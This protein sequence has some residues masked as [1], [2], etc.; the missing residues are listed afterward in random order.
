M[1]TCLLAIHSCE[2]SLPIESLPFVS[3]NTNWTTVRFLTFLTPHNLPDK[4]AAE[5]KSRKV[6][7]WECR[8][9]V[10]WSFFPSHPM[11]HY[12]ADYPRL[13]VGYGHTMVSCQHLHSPIWNL[14][15]LIRQAVFS[16][17]NLP[18]SKFFSYMKHLSNVDPPPFGSLSPHL[19]HIHCVSF[20][21]ILWAYFEKWA[22]KQFTNRCS[23]H[24]KEILSASH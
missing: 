13:C 10:V 6:K 16:S 12:Q 11:W 7:K 9:F 19:S 5:A 24:I 18:W 21:W 17:T 8:Q 4:G 23:I 20:R 14:L 22:W 3:V 2:I 1:V 15:H